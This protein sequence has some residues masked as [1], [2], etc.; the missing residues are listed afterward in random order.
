MNPSFN[1]LKKTKFLLTAIVALAVLTFSACANSEDSDSAAE[2][3]TA[4]SETT[5]APSTIPNT[6]DTTTT[7]IPTTDTPD[8]PDTTTTPP[9]TSPTQP[10]QRQIESPWLP[11]SIVSELPASLTLDSS[12]D[13]NE[14]LGRNL[15]QGSLANG[16]QYFIAEND[17][18]GM[19]TEL[20][21]VIKAG[22]V[23]ETPSQIG[24]AHFLEHMLFNGTED[25]PKNELVAFLESLGIEFGPDL[26]ASTSYDET[27]YSLSLSSPDPELVSTAMDV[28]VQ[29]AAHATLNPADVTEERGVIEAEW[30]LS[31]D[32]AAGLVRQGLEQVVFDGTP[33]EGRHPAGT[34]EGIE[35]VTAESLREFY[36]DWY[37]PQNMAI[38]A[39]GDFRAEDIQ[40]Q[41]ETKFAGLASGSLPS[42]PST[43]G[44]QFQPPGQPTAA[45]LNSPETTTNFAFFFFPRTKVADQDTPAA[46]LD[47]LASELVFSMISQRLSDDLLRGENQFLEIDFFTADLADTLAL[48]Y[49]RMVAN[50]DVLAE[51]LEQ[52]IAEVER[53]RRFGFSAEE[54]SQAKARIQNELDTVLDQSG[55]IQHNQI[56]TQLVNHFSAGTPAI[57]PTRTHQTFTEI[58]ELL[59]PELVGRWLETQLAF[60]GPMT[61]L[62]ASQ[63]EY[64]AK[65]DER[66]LVELIANASQQE[67]EPRT[68]ET[69]RTVERLLERPAPA[70]IMSQR[71]LTMD[72]VEIILS[73]GLRVLYKYT[74]IEANNVSVFATS[75]GGKSLLEPDEIISW[76]IPENIVANSGIGDFTAVELQ[77]FLSDKSLS[78][79]PYIELTREGFSG[80]A[81]TA[82]LEDLF[83]Y[84]HLFMQQP[85]A[86]PVAVETEVSGW[87]VF[88]EGDETNQLNAGYIELFDLRY[89]DNP[90]FSALP[91]LETLDAISA[92]DITELFQDRFI[93]AADFTFIVVGDVDVEIVADL[94][95]S[96]LGTLPST[97]DRESWVNREPGI[98]PGFAQTSVDSGFDGQ[99]LM[100]LYFATPTDP[101]LETIQELAVLDNLIQTR[102]LER[103]REEQAATYSPTV[104]AE[105]FTEPSEVIELVIEISGEREGIAEIAESV[106]SELTNLHQTLTEEELEVAKQKLARD[107][108]FVSNQYWVDAIE[109]VVENPTF[110]LAN[111]FRRSEFLNGVQL[112]DVKDLAREV[113]PEDQYIQILVLSN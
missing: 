37:Q 100:L 68:T 109:F 30:R 57:N 81:A 101:A 1:F 61:L 92:S 26:N 12:S 6:P 60:S 107:Y 48:P 7:T 55:T 79:Q 98:P 78:I 95:R 13:S 89:G 110:E 96:Y 29:W 49:L 91:S 42:Q 74:D 70:E 41:I 33:Y 104:T 36:E 22:S 83:A 108:S 64:E 27:V 111:V 9:D 54:F 31:N 86:A 69:V 87:R 8:T 59:T 19:Q 5:Q 53:A 56:A 99:G 102:L 67:L 11:D 4:E 20:R 94:S 45:V 15:I 18:P 71:N 17:R 46:I 105:L 72:I 16:F 43:E 34:L 21:L 65:P 88:L 44:F 73:N 47:D 66:F 112:E 84:V 28:L 62:I 80:Q 82:D 39:V 38:I 32:S 97:V 106:R 103:F 35:A 14:T 2:P 40:Q 23:N 52:T 10:P 24:V 85:K 58:L 113:F 90:Y 75:P 25:F 77:R 63:S 3:Q 50:D 51:S 93:N 76:N